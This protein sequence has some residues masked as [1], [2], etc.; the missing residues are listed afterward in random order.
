MAAENEPQVTRVI[1]GDTV[2]L[3]DGSI[4]SYLCIDAPGLGEPFY[5]EARERNR[6][7]VEGKVVELVPGLTDVDQS[8][9]LLR[10]V[11]ADGM[12][13]NAMLVEEGLASVRIEE[14]EAHSEL[15]CSLEAHARSQGRG[16]WA[17]E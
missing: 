16:M 3:A 15:L 7:L 10:Y 17:A 13:V 9:R 4:V 11:Y 2:E 1:D 14:A 8:G 12:L 5:D 6:Q